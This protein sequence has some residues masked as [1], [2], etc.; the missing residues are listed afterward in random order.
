[1]PTLAN[2]QIPPPK[3]WQEFEDITLSC[4]KIK[5][6]SNDLKKHGRL[7][8][9]QN[10][11]DI[12]GSDNLGHR[13]GIQC[14]L[15]A[16]ELT[17]DTIKKEAKKAESFKPKIQAY[18]MATSLIT[19]AKLQKEVRLFSEQNA[20]SRSFPVDIYFWEDLIMELVKDK[21]EFENHYPQFS[22]A[23]VAK[24]SL[25][26]RFLCL[27]DLAYFGNR[28][29]FFVD[30][31]FGEIGMMISGEDPLQLQRLTHTI[32]GCAQVVLSPAE[33]KKLKKTTKELVE[34]TFGLIRSTKGYPE[35]WQP[36]SDLAKSIEHIVEK[37]EY[38][39]TGEELVAYTLGK[40]LGNW[41]T[42]ATSDSKMDNEGR[43]RLLKLSETLLSSIKIHKTI[44][45]SIQEYNQS[46]SVA[47]AYIPHRVYSLIRQEIS[48]MEMN[49]KD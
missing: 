14:K 27:Y 6:R 41:D 4:L 42:R 26:P 36:T 48:T 17:I 20:K 39:L 15:A 18:Y 34:Y 23:K 21:S 12:Y 45:D 49:I 9:P 2:M 28:V 35:G 5:W 11:V 44:N 13:V 46:E 43:L 30:L 8:Q 16:E 25:G 33:Y 29:D 32:E 31:I 37:V 22:Q 7:G 38:Q 40:F 1:M 3:T 47:T 10:G 24:K 19:D